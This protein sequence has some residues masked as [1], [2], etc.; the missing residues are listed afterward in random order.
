MKCLTQIECVEWLR[1]QK[2][3]ALCEDNSP[4]VIGDFEI[5]FHTPTESCTQQ[6]LARDLIAWIGEFDSALFWITDWPFH[7]KD[8]DALI[9]RLR[10]NH[11]ENNWL[12]DKPGNFF[13]FEEKDELVGWIYLMMIFGWDGYLFVSPFPQNML[14]ISH[15]NFVWVLSLDK[16]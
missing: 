8:E 2:I 6:N 3:S 1:Q 11:G 14:Q 15:E 10:K 16:K 7:K 12:I 4:C 13:S 9:W 5:A